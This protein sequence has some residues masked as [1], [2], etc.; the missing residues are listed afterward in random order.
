M[1]WIA[2]RRDWIGSKKLDW[3]FGFYRPLGM[4]SPHTTQPDN[5]VG[6]ADFARK[7]KFFPRRRSAGKGE[8]AG[9]AAKPAGRGAAVGAGAKLLIWF[10]LWYFTGGRRWLYLA[11]HSAGRDFRWVGIGDY[12]QIW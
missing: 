9:E 8:I 4:T 2:A 12:V 3:I 6:L 10:S 5:L 1:E 11:W 7:Q